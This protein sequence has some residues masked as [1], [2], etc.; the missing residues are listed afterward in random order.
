MKIWHISDTHTF[1]G[2]LEIPENIEIVIFSGDCS[3]P[4]NPYLNKTEVDNF[5]YWFS[6]LPIKSKVFVAG[7]HDTS[8]EKRLITKLDFSSNGIVYLENDFIEIEGVKI[9]GSPITPTF[10]EGW[11]F[12]KNRSK[13]H[14][15]WSQIPIDT[16]IVITHGP[17]KGILDLSYDRSNLMEFCG[18]VAF[19]KAMLKLSPK[20]CLF[21]HI[22]NCQ[23][24]VN[25]GYRKFSNHQTI[26]SNG[27]VV[28]D[29]KFGKLCS[30]GNIFEI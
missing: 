4:K 22:H 2:L 13:L 6:K 23:D 12:N 8:I 19:T 10:G 15:L 11:A 24:I 29:G 30:N 25:T 7:N 26:Y 5:I 14:N 9:W 27:S 17:P 3:N 20:L 28:E 1:H 21:G 18:C 16:D